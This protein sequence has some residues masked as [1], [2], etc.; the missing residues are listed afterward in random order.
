MKLGHHE[1]RSLWSEP[2]FSALMAPTHGLEDIWRQS[3]HSSIKSQRADIY[4]PAE[5]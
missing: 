3:Y 2:E 4:L 5:L 1:T